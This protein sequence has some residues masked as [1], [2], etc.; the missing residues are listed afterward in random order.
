[1]AAGLFDRAFKSYLLSTRVDQTAT[2]A[3]LQAAR[4]LKAEGRLVSALEMVTS[5]R[6]ARS[7]EAELLLIELIA[8]TRTTPAAINAAN[9][10][11]QRYPQYFGDALATAARG[12]SERKDDRE[13]WTILMPMLA[14]DLPPINHFPVLRA[15]VRY[16]PGD[17]ELAVVKPL[18]ERNVETYPDAAQIL[19]IE[20]MFFE[21]TG[22]QAEATA[23]YR[24]AL[25][26][27]P[28]RV[29]VYLRLARVIAGSEPGEGRELIERALE[30]QA[31]SRQPFEPDLFLAAISELPASSDVEAL[32][33]S[34]LEWAPTNGQIAYRLGT[35]LEAQGEE[36]Q[37]IVR[38]ATRA[39]RFQ[40]GDEA[41]ALRDRARE[42][43]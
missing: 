29:T 13:A 12:A 37:R 1:M 43:L 14:L 10:M 42:Q 11:S 6:A 25:E 17:E 23:S 24:R 38:L 31:T 41:T 28:D 3:R 15:G 19:E 8:Q 27:E 2:D 36:A 7:V 39:I 26:A 20:G 40:V 9:W 32:L 16:A 18:V 34:A 4:L 30:M 5:S 33:E 22:A 35:G 21:R